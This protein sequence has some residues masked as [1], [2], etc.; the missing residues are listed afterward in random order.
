MKPFSQACENNKQPILAILQRV[1]GDAKQVLEIGSGTGQHAVHFA[2]HMPW[3]YWQ[4]SDLEENHAGIKAWIQ[5]AAPDNIGQ[6]IALDVSRT[7]WP[8]QKV[9]AVF[10]AN[11]LHIMSWPEVE[12]FFQKLPAILPPHASLAI[13]GPF[14]YKGQYTSDSNRQFDAWLKARAPHRAIRDI[15]AVDQL[16]QNSGLEWVEDNPMPANNRLLVWRR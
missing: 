12:T 2:R 6:P 16:A 1:F 4:T 7:K 13:Y 15:E 9:D 3:L 8:H 11:T 10:S 14:N 5:D